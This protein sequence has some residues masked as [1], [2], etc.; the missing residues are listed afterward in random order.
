VPILFLALISLAEFGSPSI[1][2]NWQSLEFDTANYRTSTLA[3]LI[4]VSILEATGLL[5]N[6]PLYV[7]PL[8]GCCYAAWLAIYRKSEPMDAATILLPVSLILAPYAWFYDFSL[9]IIIQSICLANFAPAPRARQN[10]ALGAF[11]LLQL[12]VIVASQFGGDLGSY[13]WF[14]I[15]FWA[16]AKILDVMRTGRSTLFAK[17]QRLSTKRVDSMVER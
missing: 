7:A 9:L 17:S 4:R 6:W 11:I 2:Q 14:P 8:I 3:T 10:I 1:T 15:L 12:A 5:P 13:F 16:V